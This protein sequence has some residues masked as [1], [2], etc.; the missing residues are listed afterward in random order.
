MPAEIPVQWI[1][2]GLSILAFTSIS[3]YVA[4]QFF[5]YRG[6]SLAYEN[7]C[8]LIQV[9]EQKINDYARQA[10]PRLAHGEPHV[11]DL[12]DL[13]EW[14]NSN[15]LYQEDQ[16]GDSYARAIDTLEKKAGDCE[17]EAILA[18]SMI[19]SLGGTARVVAIPEC[20][21]AFAMTP[22]GTIEKLQPTV[23]E[24]LSIYQNERNATIRATSIQF[25]RDET[26]TY[27]LIFDPAGGTFLGDTYSDCRLIRN[28]RFY[29]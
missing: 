28:I 26:G 8:P 21:H 7:M 27:W 29:C 10:M 11:R 17:D 19:R 14:F 24:I 2:L 15:I 20:H 12:V 23:N 4:G 13:Y 22:V 6:T 1:V 9:N 18:A 5:I 25:F 3:A 16:D